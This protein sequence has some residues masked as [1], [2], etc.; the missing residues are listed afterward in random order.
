MTGERRSGR[1]DRR[2]TPRGGRRVADTIRL[3]LFTALC[4]AAAAPASA[5]VQFGFDADSVSKA[6]QLGMPVAYG[7]AWAGSWVQKWGWKDVERKLR[8]AKAAGVVPVVQW[9]YWG[10]DIS[11]NCVE[12]GCTDRYEG[13]RKDK[14]N[15]TRLSNE[16]ADLI[17][18]VMGPDSGTLVI[19]ETEFNKNGIENYEPFDGY[20]AE[21]ADIFHAR[22]LKVVLGFGNWGRSQWKNFDRAV[23]SAD[24]LG[25]QI[26]QSS[27]RDASTYLSGAD[28]LLQGARYNR[29]TFNKPTFVTDFAFSSYP[30]PSY[31]NDQ[32][33]V[34][35]EVFARMDEFRA[36]G[37]QG[38]IWR[39]LVDDPAFDTANYHGEAER[40][41]GLLHADGSA[42][43]AFTPFLNGMLTEKAYAEAEAA[44]STAAAQQG[45]GQA[46]ASLRVPSRARGGR[47]TAGQAVARPASST[48]TR[49]AAQRP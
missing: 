35:R 48:S 4:A 34:V 43:P 7:S 47:A 27:V 49:A 32:D 38:M 22:R 13:V 16:L 6:R 42:K 19:T 2:D 29:Q 17:V 36:A 41:W 31:L 12:H 9:W 11:P 37:V 23:A 24:L 33:T 28:M 25:A 8:A 5:Q 30:E 26:L 3:A 44:Q 46:E 15:W 45:S 39:M 18:N 21:Q 10:D 1:P 20:L 14:A 40:H